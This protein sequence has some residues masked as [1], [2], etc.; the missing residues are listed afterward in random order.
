MP[1]HSTLVFEMAIEM[2][3]IHKLAGVK[4]QENR[5]KQEL[6]QFDLISINLL[7]Y[8]ILITVSRNWLRSVKHNHCTYL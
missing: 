4:F 7:T 2:L 1:D 8:V 3:N 6:G 5:L